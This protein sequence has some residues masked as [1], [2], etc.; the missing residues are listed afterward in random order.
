M[1]GG[2]EMSTKTKGDILAER[3]ETII[4]LVAPNTM[5]DQLIQ[6]LEEYRKS[7][8]LGRSVN[9]F[10]LGEGQEWHRN[11]FTKDMLPEGYRPLIEGEIRQDVDEKCLFGVWQKPIEDQIGIKVIGV[12]HWRTRR[13]LPSVKKMIPLGPEDVKCGDEIRYKGQENR[14]GV[15]CVGA[16]GI[17]CYAT[18]VLWHK[19][20]D[21]YE[22]NR[23]DGRGFV[24]CEKESN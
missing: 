22:I 2:T 12:C 8:T 6:S 1:G 23:N 18:F 5:R 16:D 13:P 19:L 11:D 7:W 4:S 20:Q 14:A 17:Q 10:T 9:G 3:I 21:F 24:P 15:L